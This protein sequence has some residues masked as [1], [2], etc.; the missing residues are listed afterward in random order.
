MAQVLPMRTAI[1]AT[2]ALVV[3]SGC[4]RTEE[5]ASC[6]GVPT[7]WIAPGRGRPVHFVVNEITIQSRQ[8]RWNGVIIDE[9]Q[10]GDYLRQTAGA[11]PQPVVVFSPDSSDCDFSTRIR[12]SIEHAYPCHD[13]S[14]WL[15]SR[16]TFEAEPFQRSNG[17]PA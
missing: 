14:C 3:A 5:A 12:S 7:G 15:G 13:G 17:P 9:R 1:P 16:A 2:L 4:G 8:I 6:V 11:A 10:L